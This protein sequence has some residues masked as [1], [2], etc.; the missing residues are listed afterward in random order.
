[1][2]KIDEVFDWMDS[3]MRTSKA[4]IAI[5]TPT[6]RRSQSSASGYILKGTVDFVG[7]GVIIKY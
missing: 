6:T 4:S 3:L 2:S 5:D 1:M 7:L